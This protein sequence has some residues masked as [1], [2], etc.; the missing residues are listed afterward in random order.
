MT[1]VIAIL[2]M[3]E[4]KWKEADFLRQEIGTREYGGVMLDIGLM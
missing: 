2:V 4:E 1:K 3:A